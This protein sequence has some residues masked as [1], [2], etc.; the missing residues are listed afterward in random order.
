MYTYMHSSEIYFLYR[1][2]EKLKQKASE[3]KSLYIH[4][5]QKKW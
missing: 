5:F 2:T 3:Y 1:L 4:L